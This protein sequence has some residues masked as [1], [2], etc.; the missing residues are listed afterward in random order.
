MVVLGVGRF[1]MSEVPLYTRPH[2]RTMG[3]AGFVLLDFEGKLEPFYLS[4]LP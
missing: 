4:K 1:I 3:Y 2:T